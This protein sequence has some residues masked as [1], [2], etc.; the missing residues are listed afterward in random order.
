MIVSPVPGTTRDAIDSICT[1][2]KR[3]YLLIDTAGIKKKDKVGYSLARFSMV[4]AL[5]SIERCDIALIVLDAR[6][7][8]V[9][10]DQKIAG[11]VERYGKGALF[12]LNKWDLI[13]D[14][15]GM[16]RTLCLEL[17]RKIWFMQYA[18]VLTISAI[19]KKRVTK[20]FPI[21]DKIINERRKR[22]PTAELNRYFR[23]V[24]ASISLPLYKGKP[25]KL[26]YITQVKIEPPAFAV[27][28]NYPPAIKAPHIRYMEKVLRNI[29]SFRGTPVKIYIK[30]KK[31][32]KKRSAE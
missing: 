3:K 8:I 22:I 10:Q 2:Y 31:R 25:V 7:G 19:E 20:V 27:F 1:Y 26:S 30:T 28:T 5:R 23:E 4:R 11:I 29:F 24:T 12:L 6:D 18:P 14:T 17:S 13:E 16:Y 21:I 15:E 9:E 32:E